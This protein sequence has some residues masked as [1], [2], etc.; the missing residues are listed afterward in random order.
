MPW[1]DGETGL[2]VEVA[3][4]IKER[5]KALKDENLKLKRENE[6]LKQRV[7]DLEIREPELERPSFIASS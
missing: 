5:F 3:E 6:Q 4:K 7:S 1:I 2:P